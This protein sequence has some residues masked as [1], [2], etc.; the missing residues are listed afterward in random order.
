MFDTINDKINCYKEKGFTAVHI[1]NQS[2]KLTC[3]KCNTVRNDILKWTVSTPSANLYC[4]TCIKQERKQ[5]LEN[6]GYTVQTTTGIKFY[7]ISCKCGKIHNKEV[8]YRSD[9]AP[10]ECNSDV[11]DNRL[12]KLKK[13]GYTPLNNN[14]QTYFEVVCNKCSTI[15]T[16]KWSYID[17]G[18]IPCIVCYNKDVQKYLEPFNYIYIDSKIICNSCNTEYLGTISYFKRNK[19]KTCSSCTLAQRKKHLNS[20]GFSVI[21]TSSISKFTLVCNTCGKH[22]LFTWST[23]NTTP[24]RCSTCLIQDRVEYIKSLNYFDDIVNVDT[25]YSFKMTCKTC[26]HEFSRLWDDI[27]NKQITSCPRCCV[28]NEERSMREFI[29]DELGV[30]TT[31]FTSSAISEIDIYCEELKLGIEYNGVYYHTENTFIPN[32]TYKYKKGQK[33]HYNKFIKAK[34][35]GITLLQFDSAEW[36]TKQEIVKS[37]LR[38]KFNK[39]TNVKYARKLT[40]KSVDGYTAEAFLNNNHIQGNVSSSIRYGLYEGTELVS[41]MC[42]TNKSNEYELVRFVS[43][44]NNTIVGAASRLFKHFLKEYSDKSIISFSDNRWF[45]GDVYPKLGFKKEYDVVPSYEYIH[46]SNMKIKYHKSNFMKSRIEKKYPEQ[47]DNSLTEYENMLLLGY[48]RIWDCGK[49]KWRYTSQS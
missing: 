23:N 30:R 32:N 44:L 41:L 14:L 6:K 16:I 10:C 42:F 46:K 28:S 45:S 19:D 39:I 2:F 22:S 15:K 24:D 18:N 38:N 48:D 40:I 37:M 29:E 36:L 26:K 4:N 1:I 21:P 33:Y 43:V 7:I 11:L 27:K 31:K 34:D 17:N 5:N 20:F 9:I 3:N 25:T 35:E 13:L 49:V 12:S 8:G 47:Y